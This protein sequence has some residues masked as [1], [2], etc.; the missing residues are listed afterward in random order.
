MNYQ[1]VATVVFGYT[2]GLTI[3]CHATSAE[4]Q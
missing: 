1:K 4:M 2:V 3:V